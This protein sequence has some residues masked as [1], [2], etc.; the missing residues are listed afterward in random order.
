M[1]IPTDRSTIY[2]KHR[3]GNDWEKRIAMKKTSHMGNLSAA[4][5]RPKP[6]F[7]NTILRMTCICT[8]L[9][10]AVGAMR[11]P[12]HAAEITDEAVLD[13]VS[14]LKAIDTLQEMQNQR[15]Q[16]T[17]ASEYE[18]YISTMFSARL[19][20]QAAYDAL[21]DSQK[22]QISSDLTA[23]LDSELSTVYYAPTVAV[24]QRTDA[25]PYEVIFKDRILYEIGHHVAGEMP[26]TIILVDTSKMGS[27][28]TPDGLYEYGKSN[29]EVTYCCDAV[30]AVEGGTHYKRLNLED[31]GYY[32]KYAA[33]HIRAI[34]QNAYPFL[35]LD[36][37]KELLKADGLSPSFV[38]SLTR[39]DIISAVQ[40]AIWAYSNSDE[41]GMYEYAGT[42][43]MTNNG[44][45]RNPLHDYTNEIWSWWD[46]KNSSPGIYDAQAAY[47][48]NT[49]VYYLCNLPG[50]APSEEQVVISDV[51][52]TRA[53]LLAGSNHTYNLGLYIYLNDGGGANDD[54]KLT[55]TSYSE[56][57]D[58]TTA[59]SGRT[60]QRIDSSTE[61]GMFVTT[62]Y[63][64]TISVVVEGTQH[65]GKGVYFYEPEGG[66]TKSQC[67]V[68]MAAGETPVRV[69][70]RFV[71]ETDIEKGLRIYKTDALAGLPLSDIPFH[72]YKVDL[73][74]G[75]TI[76]ATPTEEEIARYAT[77]DHKTG[78][79]ITDITGYASIALEDGVYLIVEEHQ[80]D[81]IKAPVDPFY[82]NIPMQHEKITEGEDGIV[83]KI[84]FL[85]IVSAYP[86]NEPVEEPE[87]PP[88]IPVVP[89]NVTGYFS[90]V[91]YDSLDESL[92][93]DNAQ[94]QVFRPATEDD[95]DVTIISSNGI[96]YAVVPVT[97]DGAPL[98]LTT[99]ETGTAN[100]PELTCGTYFLVETKAPA[101]YNLQ[102]DAIPVT[103]V[104]SVVGS[105]EVVRI[106]NDRG[107]ILPETG[108][109]GT[110][111][112][113]FAGSLLTIAASVLLISK[114]RMNDLL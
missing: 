94:F 54:L 46:T 70:K 83:T 113:L 81:K 37:M 38:D 32:G 9:L 100:S 63:G 1:T 108:G 75:E 7:K 103:V 101:G 86:K 36:E 35:S 2:C 87:N 22:A 21:T 112:F 53:E 3:S 58:G 73:D 107:N 60:S 23:K 105:A 18:T 4:K 55:V 28:W 62:K 6:L 40:M 45:F 15:S 34:V 27:H 43:E 91:K 17:E 78:T 31:S 29:Y 47:R 5:F 71:F 16:Y 110:S 50:V 82:I 109:M 65:L 114:K 24:T 14:Q 13:V 20:A 76:S 96:D 56:N 11:L 99:D 12:T 77:E 30:A 89:D 8:A 69:E 66:P 51:E 42:I 10:L 85:D 25:Y 44:I 49:L 19:A 104:S 111:V 102:E 59:I 61:Y 33:E 74:A 93:L 57:N 106:P 52:I 26:C 41:T 84:E 97:V 39:G 98:V 80:A 79:I 48:V 88:I 95:S 72:V 92:L 64:D 68:G 90:I 67:L